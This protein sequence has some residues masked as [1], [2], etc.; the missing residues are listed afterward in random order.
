MTVLQS[1]LS[2][3]SSVATACVIEFIHGL[4]VSYAITASARQAVGEGPPG[5]ASPR[6]RP[7]TDNGGTESNEMAT[8]ASTLF[9]EKGSPIAL[10]KAIKNKVDATDVLHTLSVYPLCTLSLYTLSLSVYALSLIL[11]PSC[12]LERVIG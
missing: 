6:K 4:Q 12:F 10:A 9:V 8:H 3:T 7:R 1:Y 5:K 2:V 11:I